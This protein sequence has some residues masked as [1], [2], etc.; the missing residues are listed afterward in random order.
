[1]AK[2]R[3][4][5]Q[6]HGV[7]FQKDLNLQQHHYENLKSR[8]NNKHVFTLT[9]VFSVLKI[10]PDD[11]RKARILHHRVA[12]CSSAVPPMSVSQ[13]SLLSRNDSS[14]SLLISVRALYCQ[15]SYHTCLL[16]PSAYCRQELASPLSPDHTRSG[17]NFSD[18][19]TV[20]AGPAVTTIG[21]RNPNYN[22]L[23]IIRIVLK[24][25]MAMPI[26]L[27]TGYIVHSFA[28]V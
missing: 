20:R 22:H 23:Y 7:T 18:I 12:Y 15:P 19:M 27:F 9:L 6:P 24:I 26:Q 5:I 16:R 28:S 17:M 13:L 8:K 14:C 3:R 21:I 10:L 1:M 11:V 2:R 25:E 4:F